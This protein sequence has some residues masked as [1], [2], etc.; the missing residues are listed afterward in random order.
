MFSPNSFRFCEQVDLGVP[1][2]QK[3]STTC[4]L[5][6]N[7][8]YKASWSSP[9]MSVDESIMNE[10]N[11]TF[12]IMSTV[13][14][15]LYLCYGLNKLRCS[16]NVYVRIAGIKSLHLVHRTK[17][18]IIRQWSVVLHDCV[19]I[20]KKRIQPFYLILFQRL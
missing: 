16:F 2:P 17:P 18:L 19:S 15:T 10:K 12:L 7:R 9:L 13:F 20:S 11:W 4:P 6:L 5:M 14:F 3:R 1:S 8:R